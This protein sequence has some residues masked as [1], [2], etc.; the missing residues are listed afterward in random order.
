MVRAE[1][2]AICR[3][4]ETRGE[5]VL[6]E[7]KSGACSLSLCERRIRR[8]DR[9]AG[10]VVTMIDRLLAHC[11]AFAGDVCAEGKYRGRV[12]AEGGAQEIRENWIFRLLSF[13]PRGLLE[14][15]DSND[16]FRLLT[17]IPSQG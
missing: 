15:R 13:E 14:K 9:Q 1:E 2:D 8:F 17:I 6:R 7:G 5:R 10:C 11:C 4:A 16:S 3:R 12:S